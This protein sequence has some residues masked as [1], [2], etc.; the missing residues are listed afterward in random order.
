ML[1]GSML[2]TSYYPIRLRHLLL[3]LR[4]S[5]EI[6]LHVSFGQHEFVQVSIVRL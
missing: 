3:G 6:D 1:G 4:V 2:R 5:Y